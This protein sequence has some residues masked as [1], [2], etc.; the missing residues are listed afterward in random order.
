MTIRHLCVLGLAI[1]APAFAETLSQAGTPASQHTGQ[2]TRRQQQSF[3]D[4]ALGR[5]NP[6]NSDV[7]RAYQEARE[8]I[9]HYTTDDLYFW[10]NCVSL[11]LLIG[12]TGF[13]F[14]HLRSADKKERIAATLIAQMWNGRV[15]DKIEIELRTERYNALADEHNRL[16]E[17]S[18]S[19]A[20]PRRR[21]E[22]S[23]TTRG[24][25]EES[26]AVADDQSAVRKPLTTAELV[27]ELGGESGSRTTVAAETMRESETPERDTSE[28]PPLPGAPEDPA[29]DP[30][31]RDQ[32]IKR[33]RSQI[34]ALKNRE[35]NL[36]VRL[37]TKE[38]FKN[39]QSAAKQKT[40]KQESE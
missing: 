39:Q 15:S 2:L 28:Q 14:L 10:S 29:T 38:E 12:V 18:L 5:I 3:T 11:T 23:D 37:N 9:V 4:Y 22:T 27:R 13:F 30:F 26:S 19:V 8:Q 34:Q 24:V 36:L 7:G 21:G 33:L 40:A 16:V 20:T 17:R 35:S 31:K 6:G 1:A 32:E 25:E